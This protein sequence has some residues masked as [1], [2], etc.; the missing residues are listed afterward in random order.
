MNKT[1]LINQVVEK[2]KFSKKDATAAVE[3]TFGIITKA[4]ADGDKV[5]L[6]GFGTFET[7]K[8]AERVG[9]NPRTGEMVKIA[10]SIVPTFKPGKALKQSVNR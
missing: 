7:R 6:L 10:A 3:A 8:R 9:K 2:T 4:L 1:E 5:Q